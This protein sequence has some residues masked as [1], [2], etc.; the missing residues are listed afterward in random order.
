MVLAKADAMEKQSASCI[1]VGAKAP[2]QIGERIALKLATVLIFSLLVVCTSHGDDRIDAIRSE[3][4]SPSTS[5]LELDEAIQNLTLQHTTELISEL[6][7][8][9]NAS[10]PLITWSALRRLSQLKNFDRVHHPRMIAALV[11]QLSNEEHGHRNL[12]IEG[13]INI[14]EP[15]VQPLLQELASSR[16]VSKSAAA[17]TLARLRSLP[18]ETALQLSHNVDPFLAKQIVL[19]SRNR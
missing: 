1:E 2:D 7:D 13:L 16:S 3:L 19:Y 5:M 6:C 14:G 12:A 10:Q 9:T 11:R 18:L 4:K 17:Y 15:T 8:L